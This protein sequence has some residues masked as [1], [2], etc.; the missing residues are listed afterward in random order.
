MTNNEKIIRTPI[1]GTNAELVTVPAFEELSDKR[2]MA[3]RLACIDGLTNQKLAGRL[4]R[5]YAQQ[6]NSRYVD[7]LNR[8]DQGTEHITYLSD[9]SLKTNNGITAAIEHSTFVAEASGIQQL[10]YDNIDTRNECYLTLAGLFKNNSY[11]RQINAEIKR[12]MADQ[13]AKDNSKIYFPE[14]SGFK[15]IAPD[16]AFYISNNHH[17]IIVFDEYTIAPGSMGTPEFTIPTATISR[18]LASNCYIR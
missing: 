18:I 6:A 9:Y 16:Q 10:E 8:L 5:R 14:E 7:Y 2:N 1:A 11:I 3:I 15:T 4:N 13:T 17:L 12:Q